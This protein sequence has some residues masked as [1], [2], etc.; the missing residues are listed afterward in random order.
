MSIRTGVLRV[1]RSILDDVDKPVNTASEGVQRKALDAI[2][3]GQGSDEWKAYMTLFVEDP[4]ALGDPT[5]ISAKQLARLMGQDDTQNDAVMNGR[6]AYL[7]A[8]GTCTTETAL[9]FGR[10]ASDTLDVGLV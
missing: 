8:D 9:H 10:N 4:Q 6:R 1:K 7:V 5:S 3:E 2:K